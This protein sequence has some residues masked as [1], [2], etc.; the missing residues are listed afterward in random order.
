MKND[1]SKKYKIGKYEIYFDVKNWTWQ[2]INS[3]GF[4]VSSDLSLTKLKKRIKKLNDTN[5]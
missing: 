1:I 4:G 3:F 2:A 5:N